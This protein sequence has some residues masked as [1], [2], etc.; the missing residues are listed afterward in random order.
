MSAERR[1][2]GEQDEIAGVRPSWVYEPRTLDD[3]AAILREQSAAGAAVAFRGGGTALGLGRPPRRLDAVLNTRGLSNIVEYVPADLVVT[4]EAGLTLSELQWTV[5]RRGQ[6]LALDAPEPE[7]A[8]LGGL[9][10]R[11]DFGPRRARYGALRDLVLGVTLVR[12]DGAVTRSGGKVVK[13]VAGFDLPKVVCGSLGTLGLIGR[14]TLR[15]HPLAEAEATLYLPK[16]G[17]PEL[18]DLLR[19]I[20]HAQLEPCAAVA[21]WSEGN[22]CELAVTFEGFGP[23][24]DDQCER[25]LRLGRQAQ[26]AFER[27]DGAGA[28][29]LRARHDAVR[30]AP[31]LRLRVATVP[32]RG[33][34]LRALLA[35]LFDVLVE[36]TLVLYPTLGLAFA[37]GTPNDAAALIPALEA[38][39]AALVHGGGS[40]VIEAAPPDLLADVD[41]WGPVRGGLEIMRALKQRFD[42]A[43]R[44]NPGRFV[45][46]M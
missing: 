34:A 44:L 10:A 5:A 19:A 1:E 43:G 32:S 12:A 11:A 21:L 17:G 33:A 6:R 36:P 29:A 14:V 31:A 35:P 40:L 46:G 16:I 2:G 26:L 41:P 4:A 45:G 37:A 22:A 25:L 18:L 30:R 20:R 24:V 28:A 15:L 42:P 13:N 39:R 23:A 9:L 7:R 27:L 8:T 3:A 38:A